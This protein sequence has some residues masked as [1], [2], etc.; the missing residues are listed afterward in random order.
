MPQFHPGRAAPGEAAGAATRQPDSDLVRSIRRGIDADEFELHYQPQVDIQQGLACGVEALLRWRHRGVL[1]APSEFLAEA[2]ANW[3][4]R[5]LTDRVL[6]M[7]LAQAG[8]TGS[9]RAARSRSL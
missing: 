6:D 7:P 2:E 4:I 5:P 8:A 1:L 3:V 9:A